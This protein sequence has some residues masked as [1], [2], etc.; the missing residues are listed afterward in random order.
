MSKK[1]TKKSSLDGHFSWVETEPLWAKKVA[2]FDSLAQSRNTRSLIS[3]SLWH[4]VAKIRSWV[5]A[6]IQLHLSIYLG[7]LPE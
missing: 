1:K 5:L 2:V 7:L 3:S 4:S 6:T